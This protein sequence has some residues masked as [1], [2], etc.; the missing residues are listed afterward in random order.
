MMAKPSDYPGFKALLKEWNQKLK[1]S[2]FK[3][4]E[5][6]PLL[7]PNKKLKSGSYYRFI[8]ED[9][10]IRENRAQYYDIIGEKIIQTEFD[11]ET[12]KKIM[13]LYFE[14]HSQVEIQKELQIEGHRCQ[15]YRPIHK[16]LKR[17]GLKK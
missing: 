9:P 8:Q 1:A 10:I 2:G 5:E 4:I 15:I 11:N 6:N 3:D 14:G 16:W 13:C 17:W 12:E 7:D